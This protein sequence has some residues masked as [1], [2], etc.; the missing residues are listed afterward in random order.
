MGT[1]GERHLIRERSVI[2]AARN[3]L[4]VFHH[5]RKTS[6]LIGPI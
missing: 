1:N 5:P 4:V 6:Q 2:L 3:A